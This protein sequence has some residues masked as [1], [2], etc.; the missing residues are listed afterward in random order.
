MTRNNEGIIEPLNPTALV[1]ISL[2][3]DVVLGAQI[4]DT[5][6]VVGG[7]HIEKNGRLRADCKESRWDSVETTLLQEKTK[8]EE[9]I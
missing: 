8:P 6:T 3:G 9:V 1:S 2:G 7:V 4:Q 5:Q